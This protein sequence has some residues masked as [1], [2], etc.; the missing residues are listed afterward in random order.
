[1][2]PIPITSSVSPFTLTSLYLGAAWRSDLNV[3]ILGYLDGTLTHS[4]TAVVGMD[5]PTFLSFGW[6]DLDS[7]VFH[8]YGGIYDSG[9]R[10]DGSNFVLDNLRVDTLPSPPTLPLL[11]TG[12]GLLAWLARNRRQKPR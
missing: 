11:A 12:L 7:V 6:T 10:S 2:L 3:D 4:R 8:S 5:G 9:L 1:M